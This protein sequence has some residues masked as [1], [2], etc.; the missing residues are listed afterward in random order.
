MGGGIV[1]ELSGQGHSIAYAGGQHVTPRSLDFGPVGVGNTAQ[2]AV[3]VTND[4]ILGN[5]TGWAGGGVLPGHSCH[6]YYSIAH[7]TLKYC[8]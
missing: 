2:L 8:A 5:S 7:L 1:V 4:G 6:F 3:A